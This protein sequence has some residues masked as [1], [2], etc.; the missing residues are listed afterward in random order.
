[1]SKIQRSQ[2]NVS[3]TPGTTQGPEGNERNLIFNATS[4]GKVTKGRVFSGTKGEWNKAF[5]ASRKPAGVSVERTKSVFAHSVLGERRSKAKLSRKALTTSKKIVRFSEKGIR[6][7]REGKGNLGESHRVTE[8]P[9][10]GE[11][12]L[13]KHLG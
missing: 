4:I 8:G 5:K 9:V 2:G 11:K 12:P 6:S 7:W 3:P 1:M 10:E 13:R